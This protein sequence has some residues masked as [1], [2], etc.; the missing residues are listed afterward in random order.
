M[1]RECVLDSWK[2]D[3][4]YE[5]AYLK[6]NTEREKCEHA[7]ATASLLG[8]TGFIQVGGAVAFSVIVAFLVLVISDFLQTQ[9]DIARN[10]GS[11]AGT[12]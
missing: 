12:L 6:M 8:S 5:V 10:T 7:S 9:L 11:M 3:A 2:L 1:V 4:S